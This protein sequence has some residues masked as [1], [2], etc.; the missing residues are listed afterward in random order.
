MRWVVDDMLDSK[1]AEGYFDAAVEKGA[2]DCL[3]QDEGDPWNPN[4]RT[5]DATGSM[6]DSVARL[7]RPGGVFL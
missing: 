2:M 1:L 4:Q 5:R 7:L 3:T 6:V